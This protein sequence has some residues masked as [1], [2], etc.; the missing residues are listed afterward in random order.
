MTQRSDLVAWLADRMA[1]EDISQRQ[2]ANLS[3][4]DH[5][6][7]SRILDGTRKPGYVTMERLVYALGYQ[8]V[9]VLR[10]DYDRSGR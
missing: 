5:S 8:L 3:G 4:V 2:L 7:I 10:P 9:M 1:Y 6:T